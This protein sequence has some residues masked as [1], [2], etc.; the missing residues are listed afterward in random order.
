M[1]GEDGVIYLVFFE[2]NDAKIKLTNGDIAQI[3]MTYQYGCDVNC[4]NAEIKII[5]LSEATESIPMS[6]FDQNDIVIYHG[7]ALDLVKLGYPFDGVGLRSGKFAYGLTKQQK[8]QGAVASDRVFSQKFAAA[9][10]GYG[11]D[12]L[13][14]ELADIRKKTGIRFNA[15]TWAARIGMHETIGHGI[16]GGGHTDQKPGRI[17]SVYYNPAPR[18][19]DLLKSGPGTFMQPFPILM[20]RNEVFRI[21]PQHL[22]IIKTV[23]P[24]DNLPTDNYSRNVEDPEINLY[25]KATDW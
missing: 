24:D 17:P 18:E 23:L 14:A 20:Q 5:R 6:L 19:H 12:D 1:N 13:D 16:I 25:P 22:E 21:Y 3:K 9:S 8:R 15:H 7:D 2:D 4:I 10:M 11:I